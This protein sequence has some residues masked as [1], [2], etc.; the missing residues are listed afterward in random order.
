MFA[1]ISAI[2]SYARIFIWTIAF[3]IGLLSPLPRPSE[4][5]GDNECYGEGNGQ[6]HTCTTWN[7]VPMKCDAIAYGTY[8]INSG[9]KVERRYSTECD[10][11]WTR[12]TNVSGQ[13]RYTAGSTKYGC[14]TYCYHQSVESGGNPPSSLPIPNNSM[15]YTPMKGIAGTPAI[16]CG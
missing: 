11:K 3:A 15:V 7:A 4:T 12:I 1:Q 6:L 10:A 16:S 9:A 8:M 2:H 5:L 14:S 13:T